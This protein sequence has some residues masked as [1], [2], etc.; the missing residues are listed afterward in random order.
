MKNIQTRVIQGMVMPGGWHYP[1]GHNLPNIT[2][3]TFK[4]LVQAL[5]DYRS[6]NQLPLGKPV[7]DI[8]AYICGRFPNFCHDVAGAT[9]VVEMSGPVMTTESQSLVDN[10][11][12][13]Y[14]SIMVNLST[15]DIV[16]S[17]EAQRRAAICER[18]PLNVKW[19]TN[20]GTCNDN[21]DRLANNARF[22][23]TLARDRRLKACGCLKHDNR[24]AVWM[25]DHKLRK[26]PDV[27][28]NC[29]V[30]RG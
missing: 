22:N 9:V 29:W 12:A 10:M 6:A 11:V 21:M 30:P 1:I 23:Q 28:P 27:H 24:A 16:L 13:W 14:E 17:S 20:C 26:S 18:C 4:E 19:K 2:A 25:K 7:E 3:N 8:E 15:E 5:L